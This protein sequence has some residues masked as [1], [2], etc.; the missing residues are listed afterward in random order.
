MQQYI[1]L[2]VEGFQVF[3]AIHFIGLTVHA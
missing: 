3:Q 2:I 1:L